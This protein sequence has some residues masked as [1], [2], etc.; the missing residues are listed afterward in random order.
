MTTSCAQE[1]STLI[2]VFLVAFA[3]M[4]LSSLYLAGTI[5]EPVQRLA[6]AADRVRAGAGGR[7]DHSRLARTQ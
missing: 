4:L 5:A 1:R 3:V 7:D 6:A 2:E